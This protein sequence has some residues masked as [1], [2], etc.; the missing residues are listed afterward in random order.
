MR[1]ATGLPPTAKIQF[2]NCVRSSTQV[3][4]AATTIHQTIETGNA[5]P[6]S[7]MSEAKIRAALSNPGTFCKPPTCVRPVTRRV[8]PMVTPRMMN[9]LAS[10]TMNDGSA[11]RTTTSPLTNPISKRKGEGGDDAPPEVDPE[12]SRDQRGDDAA[13]ADDGADREVELPGDHQQ[14]HGDGQDPELGRD[15]EVGRHAPRRDEAAVPG[16]D[17]RRRARR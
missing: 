2:P 7:G 17:A 4:M 14:R 10:V 3:E 6:K 8:M 1:A 11:V 16:Q 15:L 5:A 13:G 12:L 9:R